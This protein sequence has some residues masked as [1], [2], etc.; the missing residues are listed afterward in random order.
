MGHVQGV[1]SRKL[2]NG[3]GGYCLLKDTKQLLA[4]YKDVPQ[5]LIEAIV[6]ANRTR[7]DYIVDEVHQLV[8]DKVYKGKEKPVVGVYHLIMKLDGD[9]FRASSLRIT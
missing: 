5:N 8:W 7:K 3:Y 4:N 2:I 6:D 9:N 1:C